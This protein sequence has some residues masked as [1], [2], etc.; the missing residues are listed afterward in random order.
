MVFCACGFATGFNDV[1]M[2]AAP[3]SAAGA[4]YPALTERERACLALAATGK[5]DWE[6][7][8]ALSLSEKTVN[9][10]VQ[11]AKAKYRV[12]TRADAIVCGVRSG[13]IGR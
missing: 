10:Y 12:S 4:G 11:R 7:G 6:I 3:A 13:A 2:F 8:L 9:T 5:S 1:D